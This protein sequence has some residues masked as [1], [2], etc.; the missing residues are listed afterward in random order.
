MIPFTLPDSEKEYAVNIS[1]YD[2]TGNIVKQITDD[3]YLPGYYTLTWNL[4]KDSRI[5]Q[6]GIY[7]IKISVESQKINTSLIRKVIKY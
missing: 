3:Y 7:L 2:L 4:S 6:N 1:V 5:L